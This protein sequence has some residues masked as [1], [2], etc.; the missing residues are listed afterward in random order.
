MSSLT[1]LEK[2]ILN[3]VSLDLIGLTVHDQQSSD[4]LLRVLQTTH[5]KVKHF[6]HRSAAD[7]AAAVHDA[8]DEDVPDRLECS[9][10][11]LENK[12]GVTKILDRLCNAHRITPNFAQ[13]LQVK[14]V[15]DTITSPRN[16][17]SLSSKTQ[18][19]YLFSRFEQQN[20][21]ELW[22]VTPDQSSAT[23]DDKRKGKRS[24]S[25]APASTG[26][27]KKAKESDASRDSK[28]RKTT[29]D[30]DHPLFGNAGPYPGC[31]TAYNTETK[32][33]TIRMRKDVR[34]KS[35]AVHGNNGLTV[36]DWF[37]SQ[38][39]TV[40][41]GAHG[42]TQA[43]IS[44]TASKGAFSILC[45]KT[46]AGADT[47][48]LQEFD[49]CAPGSIEN[50]DTT[51]LT[52][53]VGHEAMLMSYREDHKIRVFRGVG[54]C[55][56]APNAGIRYDGLYQIVKKTSANNKDGGF[57]ITFGMKRLE[58]QAAIDLARPSAEEKRVIGRTERLFD[59]I[60]A[61]YH[62]GEESEE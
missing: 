33:V 6:A 3:D 4:I 21:G 32:N 56:G 42:A 22:V 53:S 57:I 19:Q 9:K 47:G 1:D 12:L 10:Q 16:P 36:G 50:T 54:A 25:T 37:P 35:A 62:G 40:A 2:V 14:R 30:N 39:S 27:A 44:G 48:N 8:A 46:Y 60:K 13:I 41:C 23:S 45:T 24:S 49:Y 59:E 28:I 34:H 17:F 11:Y 26:P 61:S 51:E 31:Q 5:R 55:A 29:Y 20:W 58:N 43:G 18:A 15:L 38:F 7:A 52:G